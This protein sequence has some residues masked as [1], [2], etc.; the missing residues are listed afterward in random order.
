MPLEPKDVS[1]FNR[2]VRV[3]SGVE[4]FSAH[5][6][7]HSFGFNYMAAGGNVVVLLHLMG[8]STITL[9]AH[10]ARPTHELVRADAARVMARQG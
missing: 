10:Y 2:A 6:C 3:R 5:R 9:T 4:G 7:R 8:H 1:W